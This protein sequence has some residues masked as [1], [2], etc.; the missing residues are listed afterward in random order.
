M[1]KEQNDIILSP[2]QNKF[3][4]A[5]PGTGKTFVL[6]KAINYELS[7]NKLADIVAFTFTVKAANQLIT[8]I[9]N[10]DN[11]NIGT[12]HATAWDILKKN[13]YHDFVVIDET[14]EKEILSSIM[15]VGDK[16]VVNLVHSNLNLKE[17]KE[18]KQKL[19]D[20]KNE[21][22]LITYDEIIVFASQI[23][24]KKRYDII[25]VDEAQDLSL[26][27]LDFCLS[28]KKD[29]GKSFFVGDP[30]QAIYG[31]RGG[32]YQLVL[33][34]LKLVEN[35]DLFYLTDNYRS[36][37]KIID[38][39]N[40]IIREMNLPDL[41]SGKDNNILGDII[42]KKHPQ[43][44][45]FI[46]SKIKEWMLTDQDGSIA[47]LTR[48]NHKIREIEWKLVRSCI[49]YC[50]WG[51]KR[52]SEY[53]VVR[54]VFAWLSLT[55][56]PSDTSALHRA[57][58]NV[59]GIGQAFCVKFNNV[60]DIIKFSESDEVP[61]GKKNLAVKFIRFFNMVLSEKTL[62]EKTIK[63]RE[64]IDPGGT[65]KPLEN[66][67]TLCR[68]YISMQDFF[69]DLNLNES[70]EEGN[71]RGVILSTIHK[72]KGLEFDKVFIPFVDTENYPLKNA[73]DED[74][75]LR[76]LYVGATR[77]KNYLCLTYQD[78][79]SKFLI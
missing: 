31:W 20:K 4:I 19:N 6:S 45:Y 28:L 40:G 77:A 70:R 52:I 59:K 65:S 9:E 8:R 39:S 47:I 27:Q 3:I 18:L 69:N 43:E 12:F 24:D 48:T 15:M 26:D 72:A 41:K 54:D 42:I 66:I 74:E 36:G 75:E 78:R 38:F 64:I 10:S 49:P 30:R 57:M 56:F 62:V 14:K 35:I 67:I 53:N 13:G 44:L 71:S 5:G 22:K 23:K 16:K 37:N 33:E 29:G 51:E 46:I 58:K 50:I 7:Q 76:I 61:K 25:F 63:I 17:N 32:D 60:D 2:S 79:A 34:R 21:S 55:V 73:V 1:N 11:V 68:D